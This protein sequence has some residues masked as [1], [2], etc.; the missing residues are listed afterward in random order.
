MERGATSEHGVPGGQTN[1]DAVDAASVRW[2]AA[3][4]LADQVLAL[5]LGR[6]GLRGAGA[7]VLATTAVL[8][9]VGVMLA[10]PVPSV[11]RML[12]AVVFL[13]LALVI[14]AV[15]L[16][17]VLALRRSNRAAPVDADV[18]MAPLTPRERQAVHRAVNGRA[19]APDDRATVVD[20]VAI[21]R[22]EGR[23]VRFQAGATMAFASSTVGMGGI[24]PIWAGVT[25][26]WFVL[27]LVA[28][29]DLRLAERYLCRRGLRS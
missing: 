1:T 15:R 29:R 6:D 21:L 16:F 25:V 27:L 4:S 9:L 13:V 20:A 18:V 3:A 7:V 8:G 11:A 22:A 28:W 23:D 14:V 17:H 10:L 26:L 12:T 2:A 19:D 24:W 5:P